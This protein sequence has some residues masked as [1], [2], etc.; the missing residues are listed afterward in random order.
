MEKIKTLGEF[1]AAR[2]A[3][4]ER[5]GARLLDQDEAT[6]TALRTDCAAIARFAK[7]SP[8]QMARLLAKRWVEDNFNQ[9]SSTVERAH[10][11]NQ[12]GLRRIS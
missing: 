8:D 9:L 6:M 12:L 3:L 5:Y 7:M 2:R 11:D 4:T 10:D 1:G